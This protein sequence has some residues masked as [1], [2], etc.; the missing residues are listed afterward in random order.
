MLRG[1]D[2]RIS[3][4]TELPVHLGEYPLKSVVKGSEIVL[5]NLDKYTSV[6]VSNKRR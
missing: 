2:E 4:A 5:K 1:L 6:L 3:R